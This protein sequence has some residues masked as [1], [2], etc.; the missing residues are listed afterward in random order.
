[1]N[2]MFQS[3]IGTV[4]HV[5]IQISKCFGRFQSLIGTVQHVVI[6]W[7]REDV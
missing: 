6:V 4:Q 3:L 2:I 1:M 7:N 5:D